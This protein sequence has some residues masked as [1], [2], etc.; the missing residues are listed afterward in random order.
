MFMNIMLGL[1]KEYVNRNFVT[2][3][4]ICNFQESYPAFK[5]KQPNE[6][7]GLSKFSTLIPKWCVLAGS[8]MT[9]SVCVCS[10]HQN[11]MLLVD[12][13]DWDLRYKDLIKTIV[14][15]PESNK[16]MTYWCESCPGTATL[17]EFLDKELNEHE[18]DEEINYY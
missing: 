12:T 2:C 3:K 15:N 9:H 6:N 11:V 18:N 7:I 17:K 14:C 16:W 4:R 1:I 10:A 5:K 13:I 8:K